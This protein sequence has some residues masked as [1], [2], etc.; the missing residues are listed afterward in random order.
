MRS[1]S[2][3][4]RADGLLVI[5]VA[6]P[7]IGAYV[8]A[9][10]SLVL[11]D[12]WTDPHSGVQ[13]VKYQA[14]EVDLADQVYNIHRLYDVVDVNG[15]VRRHSTTFRTRILFRRELEVLLHQAGYQAVRFLGDHDLDPWEPASPR[16]IAVVEP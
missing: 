14:T 10:G 4:L 11:A 2:Q 12:Q 13:V 3:L 8:A 7:H 1:W 16:I 9:D 15:R 5:D 6:N